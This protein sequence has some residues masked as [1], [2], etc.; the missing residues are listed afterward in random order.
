MKR[1]A[2]PWQL[3]SHPAPAGRL[4]WDQHWAGAGTRP[5]RRKFLDGI[6]ERSTGRIA[7]SR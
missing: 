4:A 3:P 2:D 5:G 7:S 1:V 6:W